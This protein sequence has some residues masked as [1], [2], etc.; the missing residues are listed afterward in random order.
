MIIKILGCVFIVFSAFKIG[1]MYV[2]NLKYEIDSTQIF[3]DLFEIIIIK[4]EY[5][6]MP[7]LELFND[8]LKDDNKSYYSFVKE[9]KNQIMSGKTLKE[10]IN[11]SLELF[12]LKNKTNNQVISIIK[13]ISTDFGNTD[14]NGQLSLI[15]CYIEQLKKIKNEQ[16]KE[17][18]SKN[19]LA[20]NLSV[21][22][23]IAL[24]ILLI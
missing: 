12:S 19:K 13:N 23:G 4:L 8:I 10:S 14:L 11:N 18:E 7:V 6:Q 2:K 17:Y 3:I 1:V 5:Q 24:S 16:E 21:Y 20:L 15:C 9:C 22:S